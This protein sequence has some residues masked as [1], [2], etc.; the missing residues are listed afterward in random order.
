MATSPQR[1][2]F[3]RSTSGPGL[4]LVRP[5]LS[6]LNLVLASEGHFYPRHQ[7]LNYQLIFVQRGR[8]RCQLNDVPLELKSREVLIV[9]RGDWHE[10]ILTSPVRY[11]T[12]NFDLAGSD[13]R[14]GDILFDPGV[15]PE[16]QILRGSNTDLWRL[17]ERMQTES[18]RGDHVVAHVENAMLLQLFWLLVRSLPRERLSPIFLQRS[19]AQAFSEQLR[20]VFE[21][22]LAENLSAVAI[23]GKLGISVR[24]L[25]KRCREVSG[26]PP[27]RAFM[28][29]KMEFAAHALRRSDVAIKEISHRLGFQNQYH[30]SRVFRRYFG[31]PPSSYRELPK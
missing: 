17:L 28:Q 6:S 31:A 4:E 10:D 20:R 19:A 18:K 30:F 14:L 16:A 21:H 13:G 8:Y 15:T 2:Y 5:V 29:H 25:T 26:R 3:Y 11:F 22:H 24:T 9:K 27:A 12:V 7:H 23:A 1:H